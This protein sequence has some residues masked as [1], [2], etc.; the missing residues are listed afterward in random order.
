[1][2]S[3]ARNTFQQDAILQ[4]G[5]LYNIMLTVHRVFIKKDRFVHTEETC[6]GHID[7]NTAKPASDNTV[8]IALIGLWKM[9]GASSSSSLSREEIVSPA[10]LTALIMRL[11]RIP[12]ESGNVGYALI[13]VRTGGMFI[14]EGY[15][16]HE[17][18]SHL[19]LT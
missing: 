7:P 10:H 1:M 11:K 8:G 3:S 6:R 4:E 9:R 15:G 2:T 5:A 16:I 14:I 19:L 18:S 12:V 17:H 13:M